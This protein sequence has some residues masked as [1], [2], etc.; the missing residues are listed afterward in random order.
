MALVMNAIANSASVTPS[1]M[2]S[3]GAWGGKFK[4]K[5]AFWLTPKT[6]AKNS[7][8]YQF[9]IPASMFIYDVIIHRGE[10]ASLLN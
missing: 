9:F 1:H 8:T 2:T 3:K 7:T 10:S 6:M 4:P 5:K